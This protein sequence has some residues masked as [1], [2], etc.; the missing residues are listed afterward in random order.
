MVEYGRI[1]GN[2]IMTSKM[3]E[4]YNESFRDDDGELKERVVSIEEQADVLKAYGWK[5]VDLVDESKMIAEEGYIIEI[6][7][8]D[9]GEK[10]SYRYIKAF[11]KKEVENK[12]RELKK[13]LSAGDYKII[14][15]YEASLL[16]EVLPY[17]VENL[18]KNRNELRKN[19][20][21]FEKLLENSH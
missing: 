17:N 10:I 2:G 11:D 5:P 16:K 7:P 13:Q 4:P 12:I 1:D 9:A 20:N 8:Y 15:C 3:L 6:S 19:I 21:E 14:K 18:H